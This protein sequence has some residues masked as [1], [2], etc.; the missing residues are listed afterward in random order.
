MNAANSSKATPY[1]VIALAATFAGLIYT[2]IAMKGAAEELNDVADRRYRSYL[3]ADEL[4]QSSDDLTRLGRTYVVTGNPEF[5]REYLRILDIRNG[6]APRPQDYHRIYWDF[7]AAGQSQPRPNGE[8]ISLQ[9][10]MVKA[11]FTDAEFAKLKEAQANSDGLVELETRAMNAVK[12]L[13]DAQGDSAAGQPDMETARNLVHGKQY[14]EFKAQIMKPLDEFFMLVEHRTETEMA[15]AEQALGNAQNLFI[16]ILVLLIAEIALLIFL[17]RQQTLAQLGSKPQ[18]LGNVLNEI[19]SGNLGVQIPP[20]SPDSALGLVDIMNHKLKTLIGAASATSERLSS[21]INQVSQVIED[22]AQRASQQNDMTDLVATAVH[23][24]GLTVQE[25]ARSAGNAATASQNAQDEAKQ[26][27]K[28]VGES[29]AHIER[30]ADDIGDASKAVGELA[31][32]V[33]SIDQVLAVIR[34]IS[35]Q[36]NL[37]ALNAAI[38]AARAGELGR[39]FAVVADEVRTLAGRTQGSTDEIQ[40]MIQRLKQGADAA[41][42]SMQA[43]YEATRTGVEASQST[44]RSLGAIAGQIENI[45]DLNHQVATATEQQSSVTEEINRNV[46]GIADLAHATT[47]EA[48]RCQE[49]CQT[50]RQLSQDLTRQMASFRL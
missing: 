29:T 30:M 11:G 18:V 36:T 14:H 50:L 32:Q 4:R 23:E 41:V 12:G 34:G 3:L 39:G 31:E 35:E 5:E 22:T 8:T 38:E 1:V 43:G 21:A 45:S 19:A 47:R 25:I 2:F 17:G 46:Q 40:Q 10:L 26:A 9:D 48:Q 13:P 6:K 16:S 49:D 27:S 7:V 20:T 15:A 37:L 24:M 33:A 28:V 42:G 44:N